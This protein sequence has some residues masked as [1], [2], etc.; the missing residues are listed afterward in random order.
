MKYKLPSLSLLL[1][2]FIYSGCKAPRNNPLDPLNPDYNFGTIEGVVQSIGIPSVGISDVKVIWQNA[3]LI[4]ETDI[5]GRYRLTNIPINN[6]NLVFSKDG[7]KSDTLQVIWGSSKRFFTQVFFNRIPTLDSILFYSSFVNQSGLPPVASLSVRAWV[8]DLDDDVDTVFVFNEALTIKKPLIFISEEG[9]YRTS[10]LNSEL[11]VNNIE[12]TVGLPFL[13]LAKD[14]FENEFT[15]GEDRITRVIKDEVTGLYPTGD[16]TIKISSQ[17]VILNWNEFVSGYSFTY[18]VEVYKRDLLNTEL[19]HSLS[20]IPS[21]SVSYTLPINLG[22]GNYY[23]VIWIVDNYRN[24]S[25]TK[26]VL[27]K[28]EA[29]S[30]SQIR[31]YIR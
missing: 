31:K 7:Y 8:T 13:I 6:G 27:F 10:I 30:T 25:R 2:I 14:K 29:D 3:N 22:L 1:F 5:T 21:D 9:N 20:G 19:M 16:S 4:A 11:S 12:E 15:L 23:W 26:P 17:P 28:I 24:R 18:L